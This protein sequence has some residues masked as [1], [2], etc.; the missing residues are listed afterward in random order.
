M[1]WP[2]LVQHRIGDP[3]LADVVQR[4]QRGQQVD[5]IRRQHAPVSRLRGQGRGEQPHVLLGAPGVTPGI[6]VAGLG[7]RRERLDDELLGLLAAVV[8][9]VGAAPF[10]GQLRAHSGDGTNGQPEQRLHRGDDG[11]IRAV[12]GPGRE[13]RRGPEDD[14]RGG[15]WV[16]PSST[17]S[18]TASAAAK[19]ARCGFDQADEFRAG[20]RR[21]AKQGVGDGGVQLDPGKARIDGGGNDVANAQGRG[22]DEDDAPVDAPRREPSGQHVGRREVRVGAA[23][24]AQPDR[25]LAGGIEGERPRAHLQPQGAVAGPVEH[26]SLGTGQ[27]HRGQRQRRVGPAGQRGQQRHRPQDP[28]A[29][30]RDVDGPRRRRGPAERR[31]AAHRAGR[32]EE[33]RHR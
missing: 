19:T 16:G 21:A 15:A 1:R 4:R 24:T 7:E 8:L 25:D 23:G 18:A 33:R 10:R 14:H 32:G 3:D 5:P 2:R 17:T 31:H 27:L 30:G 22:A 6:D 12:R 9:R 29:V 26:E 28:V 13:P 20:A 11:P